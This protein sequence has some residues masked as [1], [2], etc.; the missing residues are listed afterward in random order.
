RDWSSDVC[1]S[2]LP[3]FS[4]CSSA[5]FRASATVFQPSRPGPGLDDAMTTYLQPRMRFLSRAR[6]MFSAF[7][8]EL[9]LWVEKQRMPRSSSSLRICL[10][11]SSDHW[12]Y[13]A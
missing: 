3:D 13:G 6:A 10:V 9:S 11:S 1:S 12:K 8:E 5:K 2:D 7:M 4:N